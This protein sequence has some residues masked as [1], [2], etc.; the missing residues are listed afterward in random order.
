M[1]AIEL[2]FQCEVDS[3]Q[4]YLLQFGTV[5]V[6]GILRHASTRFRQIFPL[7]CCSM[8]NELA[9]GKSIWPEKVHLVQKTTHIEDPIWL[10]P[11]PNEWLADEAANPE[12]CYLM[13][14]RITLAF[15]ADGA[16]RAFALQVLTIDRASGCI[17]EVT[18]FLSPELFACFGLPSEWSWGEASASLARLS[19]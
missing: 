5:G 3:I 6:P 9:E 4:V 12:A 2:Q 7:A 1:G 16:Y 18:S 15:S 17:A 11:L 13:Q 8:C 10:E 14:E 19:S